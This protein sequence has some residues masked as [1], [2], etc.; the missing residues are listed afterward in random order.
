M[1]KLPRT[2]ITKSRT[3]VRELIHSFYG[4]YYVLALMASIAA[5]A[6]MINNV[7]GNL[8]VGS[9]DQLSV[10]LVASAVGVLMALLFRYIRA[11]ANKP[12]AIVFI[13]HATQD[14]KMAIRLA[15]ELNVHNIRTLLPHKELLIGDDI[16]EKTK[17]LLLESDFFVPLFS[18]SSGESAF[19]VTE[20]RQARESAIP[21]LPVILGNASLPE[22]LRSLVY[23]RIRDE[24]QPELHELTRA[25]ISKCKAEQDVALTPLR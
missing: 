16:A 14:R 10:M 22:S 7:W 13:S 4:Y 1:K 12:I 24:T 21:V 3:T 25:I 23:L 6:G 20:V 19:F 9:F 5:L 2:P 17:A 15:E 11:A 8:Q 18:R